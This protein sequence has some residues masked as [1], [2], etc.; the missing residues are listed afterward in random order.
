MT[1]DVPKRTT[2]LRWLCCIWNI[3]LSASV[4]KVSEIKLLCLCWKQR[5]SSLCYWSAKIS[6]KHLTLQTDPSK[7][8]LQNPHTQRP[9]TGYGSKKWDIC[10]SNARNAIARSIKHFFSPLKNTKPVV[11]SQTPSV[12]WSNFPLRVSR[13]GSQRAGGAESWSL[14]AHPPTL[15]PQ[16]Q[17][18]SENIIQHPNRQRPWSKSGGLVLKALSDTLG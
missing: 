2:W 8:A 15:R 16:C 1:Y 3:W 5:I 10:N 9:S 14:E 17:S 4:A 13:I 18:P 6:F 11:L 12:H 7:S